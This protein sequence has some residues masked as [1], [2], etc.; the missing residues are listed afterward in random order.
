MKKYLGILL[1]L[2]FAHL[3]SCHS[4]SVDEVDFKVKYAPSHSYSQTLTQS[5]HSEVTYKGSKEYLDNLKDKG[6][7]NPTITEN[8]QEVKSVIKTGKQTNADKFPMTIEFIKST[9]SSG[10]KD[11]PD[12]TKIYGHGSTD[13]LPTIDSISSSEMTQE[14][15]DAI[16]QSMQSVFKQLDLP[17]KKIKIGEQFMRE[18]P[19]SIPIAGVTIDMTITT[20]YKLVSIEHDSANFDIS[21]VYTMKTDVTGHVI[22]ATGDGKGKLIY[23]MKNNFYLRYQ[24]DTNMNMQLTM[25]KF[26]LEVKSNSNFV[27]VTTITTEQ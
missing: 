10:K 26:V 9:S 16:T 13:E 18:N 17:E 20:I 11:I 19:L 22:K 2:L 12:G 15:K 25:D 1:P 6:V 4:Q 23:D 24:I 7:S 3:V 8:S 21:Q 27:Q 5:S 14:Y